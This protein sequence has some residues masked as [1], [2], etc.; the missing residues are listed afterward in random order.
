MYD[1][2]GNE[3][4]D[5][6]VTFPL[7]HLQRREEGFVYTRVRMCLCNIDTDLAMMADSG[8]GTIVAGMHEAHLPIAYQRMSSVS[9]RVTPFNDVGCYWKRRLQPFIPKR[10]AVVHHGRIRLERTL[11][12]PD[13]FRR[14]HVVENSIMGGGSVHTF[15]EHR[16]H[17]I[18]LNGDVTVRGFG[19]ACGDGS[20]V[21]AVRV[22]ARSNVQ[23]KRVCDIVE[24]P[25]VVAFIGLFG[26][27]SLGRVAD[28]TCSHVL[29][30]LRL[31]TPVMVHRQVI[32][33]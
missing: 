20:V 32:P 27:P 1:R 13:T 22:T 4:R 33:R 17:A 14:V 6:I 2:N 21:V 28:V 19:G 11:K 10:S 12:Q 30:Q 7:A 15:V 18:F 9:P 8:D 3:F 26:V 31:G 16:H 23:I 29:L 24:D 25:T 5:S